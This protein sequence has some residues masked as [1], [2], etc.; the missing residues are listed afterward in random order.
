MNEEEAKPVES[1]QGIC[2]ESK[3]EKKKKCKGKID[4]KEQTN[5]A[6]E[7]D[8]IFDRKNKKKQKMKREQKDSYEEERCGKNKKK[9]RKY[10][11]TIEKEQ[12]EDEMK[13]NFGFEKKRKLK[14]L[15]NM[16]VFN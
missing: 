14:N 10:E 13:Q 16:G 11:E 5:K 7:N 1:I 9:K 2:K 4:M 3:H 6:G 15:E 12:N 8:E